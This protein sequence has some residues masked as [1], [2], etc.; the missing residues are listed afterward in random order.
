MANLSE[1]SEEPS[2]TGS[3]FFSEDAE[4]SSIAG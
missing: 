1:D 4:L 3:E 2:Q